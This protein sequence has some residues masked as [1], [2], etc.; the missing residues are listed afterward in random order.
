MIAVNDD[1]CLHLPYYYTAQR[2]NP[3]IFN[4]YV[5]Y[6]C[7]VVAIMIAGG[8]F[9]EHRPNSVKSDS[10]PYAFTRVICHRQMYLASALLLIKIFPTYTPQ[11]IKYRLYTSIF[12]PSDHFRTNTSQLYAP[13]WHLNK[14][15]FSNSNPI[16]NS[17]IKGVVCQFLSAE[18]PKIL[19]ATFIVNKHRHYF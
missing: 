2:N 12:A 9:A 18:G 16:I 15:I 1:F 19:I 6:S 17:F 5:F 13:L 10:W 8:R 3:E 14:L 11:R 4:N 7:T